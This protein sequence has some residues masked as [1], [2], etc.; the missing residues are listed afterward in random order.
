MIQFIIARATGARPLS[1]IT[2]NTTVCRAEPDT[3]A[4]S[5]SGNAVSMGIF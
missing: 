5:E 3:T 4:L 2:Y 1:D